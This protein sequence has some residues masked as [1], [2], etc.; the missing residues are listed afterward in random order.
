MIATLIR[1]GLYRVSFA[2]RQQDVI[3]GHG[4]DAILAAIIFWGIL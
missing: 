4:C 3:A 1:P 2:G